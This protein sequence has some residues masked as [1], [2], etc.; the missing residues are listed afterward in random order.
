MAVEKD[1]RCANI[2]CTVEGAPEPLKLTL[3]GACIPAGDAAMKELEFETVVRK[4]MNK[5]IT[6]DNPSDKKWAINPT[7]SMAGSKK[8]SAEMQYFTGPK[9][10]E[11]PPKGKAEYEVVYHPLT[12]TRTGDAGAGDEEEEKKSLTSVQHALET[13]PETHEGQ[14]FFPLPDGSALHYRLIGKAAK[15]PAEGNI[16]E[17]VIA[18][19]AHFISVTEGRTGDR[20]GVATANIHLLQWLVDQV[21]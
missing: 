17:E 5:A 10:L 7:I 8:G 11:V 6:I 15:P 2:Q 12:M 14:L 20:T 4:A 21:E 16:Q 19:Q 1:I 9:T 3:M 13:K 18:K